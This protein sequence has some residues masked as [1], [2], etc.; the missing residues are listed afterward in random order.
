MPESRCRRKR[1]SASIPATFRSSRRPMSNSPAGGPGAVRA[2][3]ASVEF[4]GAVR[5][6]VRMRHVW[7]SRREGAVGGDRSS[8][9]RGDDRWSRSAAVTWRGVPGAETGRP[10]L[11]AMAVT[12]HRKAATAGRRSPPDRH[13][14]RPCQ[15]CGWPSRRFFEY[16]IQ[17]DIGHPCRFR[18]VGSAMCRGRM[19]AR[20][21]TVRPVVGD[22]SLPVAVL[23]ESWIFSRP[24][25][26]LV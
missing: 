21:R 20:R 2:V 12:V 14:T 18:H 7:A 22:A 6:A 8:H 3:P 11:P 4:P 24:M 13:D 10:R 16:S 15:R 25:L 9:R 5:R 17:L 23:E 1:F 26:Q 19:V